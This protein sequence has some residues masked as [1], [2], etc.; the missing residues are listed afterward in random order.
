MPMEEM[1]KVSDR[2]SLRKGQN[3]R[4]PRRITKKA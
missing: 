2:K 3:G 4:E 1:G